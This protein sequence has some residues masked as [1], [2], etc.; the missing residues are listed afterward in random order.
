MEEQL[1]FKLNIL[2]A[3]HWVTGI[4]VIILLASL[5]DFSLVGKSDFGDLCI[6]SQGFG[7]QTKSETNWTC[8]RL[9]KL[10]KKWQER[11]T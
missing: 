11:I 3:P 4:L 2:R 6:Q 1:G 5:L 9:D 7:S 10:Q 8:K